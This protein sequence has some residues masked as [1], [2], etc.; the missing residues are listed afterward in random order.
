M[1]EVID[2][3]KAINIPISNNINPKIKINKRASARF[4]S[5]RQEKHVSG[6]R[7]SIEVGEMMLSCK[8]HIIKGILAHELLH[9]CYGCQN[10]GKRWKFYAGAM[11][12]AY[13]YHI[14]RTSSYEE[15][16]IK[17]PQRERSTKYLIVCQKCG[18]EFPREKRS[19]LV[20]QTK[21]YKCRCGGELKRL[22]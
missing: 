1:K 2:Q 15:L 13:K 11:N 5:C 19:K 22:Q 9:T 7:F 17:K 18:A 16:G 12:H 14:K 4:A 8:P 21:Q 20:T 3:I 10:H 6:S